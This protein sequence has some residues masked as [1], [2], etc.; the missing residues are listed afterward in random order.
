MKVWKLIFLAAAM[1]LFASP[2]MSM[3]FIRPPDEYLKNTYDGEIRIYRLSI[4]ELQKACFNKR[5]PLFV[6]YG[7]AKHL[8]GPKR[9]TVFIP[10]GPTIN[11]AIPFGPPIISVES[12]LEH[13]MAHCNG[14]PK[15][16]PRGKALNRTYSR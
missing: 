4:M 16:H 15:H 13:E 6:I 1:V 9:C 12:I 8:E 11:V 2:S 10:K 3:G 14:W 5:F 7:C